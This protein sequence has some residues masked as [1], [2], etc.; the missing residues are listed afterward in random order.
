MAVDAGWVSVM[1][2]PEV[3]MKL[4]PWVMGVDP[5]REIRDVDVYMNPYMQMK[6]SMV[7]FLWL[8]STHVWMEMQFMHT[9]VVN[10]GK[11]EVIESAALVKVYPFMDMR[12]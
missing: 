6:F 3:K 8:I 2:W 10:S 11:V 1:M 5:R 7:A 4:E 12:P 9:D